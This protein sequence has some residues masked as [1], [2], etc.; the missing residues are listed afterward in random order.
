[1][2]LLDDLRAREAA[3]K[4]EIEEFLWNKDSD[5]SVDHDAYAALVARQRALF[6][7]RYALED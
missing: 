6:Q 3:L 1:M 2:D 7:Q 5:G 4:R